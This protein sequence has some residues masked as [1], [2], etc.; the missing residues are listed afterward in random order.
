MQCT[1]CIIF[2]CT[3]KQF[4]TASLLQ[5]VIAGSFGIPAANENAKISIVSLIFSSFYNVF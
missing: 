1:I 2:N 4:N 5:M 3:E